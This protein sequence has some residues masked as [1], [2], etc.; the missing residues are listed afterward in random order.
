VVSLEQFDAQPDGVPMAA[1]DTGWHEPEYSPSTGVAWRW[2]TERADL[3]VRPIGA[4][5]RPHT[6]TIA[7]ESPLRYFDAAPHVRVTIGGKEIAAFDPA[8]DFEQ[9]I[10]LPP[11]VLA[12]AGGRVTL[13]T[14]KFFVPADRGEGADRRHLALRIYRVHVE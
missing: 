10:T 5:E 7:G 8:T 14:T 1:F 13:E 2:M 3:W 6:L 9:T 12:A 11:E 4:R